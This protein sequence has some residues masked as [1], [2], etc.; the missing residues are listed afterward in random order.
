MLK[1]EAEGNVLKYVTEAE[2]RKQ[3]SNLRMMT[4]RRLYY[5]LLLLLNSAN[6]GEEFR[7]LLV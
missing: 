7:I 5:P 1:T 2:C 6:R 3:R 4:N